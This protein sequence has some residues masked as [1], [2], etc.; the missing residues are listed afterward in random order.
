MKVVL[1]YS[2]GLDSTVLL[3][4]LRA[5][6]HEVVPLAFQYGQSHG[7]EL[8]RAQDICDELEVNLWM[9]TLPFEIF[10]GS[11]LTGGEGVVIPN[12][13]MV[14]IAA[15]GSVAEQLHADAVAIGVQEGDAET[16]ADCRGKFCEHTF[17]SLQ[18]A[19]EGRVRLMY[20]FLRKS[21]LDV[22]RRGKELGVPFEKTW[23]CYVGAD[24]P[25]GDCPACLARR[26][27]MFLAG[28]TA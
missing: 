4:H 22:V 20:P 21:K 11:S 26:E 19:T 28:V 8:G 12:R 13:N 23:S 2:G 9:V 27:A 1:L 7:K 17:R 15:A 16:W 6:G 24:E 5:E 18:A 3:Y 10:V 14:F 25:C